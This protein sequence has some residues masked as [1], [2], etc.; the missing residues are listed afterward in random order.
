MDIKLGAIITILVSF[1][2]SLFIEGVRSFLLKLPS[3]LL[4]YFRDKNFKHCV[5]SFDNTKD[6]KELGSYCFC[7]CD[8]KIYIMNAFFLPQAKIENQTSVN[9]K[10]SPQKIEAAD[11]VTN[12]QTKFEINQE[13]KLT[14]DQIIEILDNFF[15]M[16]EDK[17]HCFLSETLY[18]AIKSKLQK[19]KT[20]LMICVNDE[21]FKAI[22]FKKLSERD[23]NCPDSKLS[24]EIK[25]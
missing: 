2:L 11:I 9:S 4:K 23:F 15:R 7:S 25:L 12:N 10:L 24:I 14:N 8:N 16:D 22:P 1:L 5:L 3:K 21:Q 19:R 13:K 18:M 17:R 20:K 6:I